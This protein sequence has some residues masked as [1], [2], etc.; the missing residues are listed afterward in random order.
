MGN[1]TFAAH[2]H[3]LTMKPRRVLGGLFDVSRGLVRG[4]AGLAAVMLLLAGTV[5]LFDGGTERWPNYL[6]AAGFAFV[7]A[8]LLLAAWWHMLLGAMRRHAPDGEAASLASSAHRSEATTVAVVLVLVAVG[9]SVASVSFA[10]QAVD[11]AGWERTEASPVGSG[12]SQGEYR[13]ALV[14]GSEID[15]TGPAKSWP[16]P[17][18]MSGAVLAVYVDPDEPGRGAAEGP[19]ELGLV[20]GFGVIVAA[21]CGS[22]ARTFR[23][24]TTSREM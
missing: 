8:Y 10:V 23:R 14:D 13:F 7:P 6:V 11:R 18:E 22:W 24:D 17:G 2:G 12:A 19:V 16:Q 3:G 20:A 4:I 1:P 9:A 5:W 15:V 21:L